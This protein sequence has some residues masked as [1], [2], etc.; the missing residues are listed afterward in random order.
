MEA[1]SQQIMD[2]ILER[3]IADRVGQESQLVGHSHT[4][5]VTT[6]TYADGSTRSVD[7]S[8]KGDDT[9]PAGFCWR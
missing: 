6:F 9:H 1:T 7:F 4:E 2:A 3:D 5:R 8:L